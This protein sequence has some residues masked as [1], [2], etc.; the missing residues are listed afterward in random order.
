MVWYLVGVAVG[1]LVVTVVSAYIF[2]SICGGWI[3]RQLAAKSSNRLI[4][5]C[6]GASLAIISAVLLKFIDVERMR[7]GDIQ[8]PDIVLAALVVFFSVWTAW[9]QLTLADHREKA[10]ERVTEATKKANDAQAEE[11]FQY[12]VCESFLR[13]V[14]VKKDR[15]TRILERYPPA[16]RNRKKSFRRIDPAHQ[17]LVAGR[18]LREVREGLNPEVQIAALAEATREIF[19]IQAGSKVGIRVAYFC[20]EKSQLKLK[21]CH[22]GISRTPFMGPTRKDTQHRFRIKD[23]CLSLAAEA[24]KTG[25]LLIVDD[26]DAA[27]SGDSSFYYCYDE[28]RPTIKSIVAIPLG[29]TSEGKYHRHVI[30]LDSNVP[31]FFNDSLLDR[32][33]FVQKNLAPRLLYEV[34]M[35]D[36]LET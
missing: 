11:A 15:V 5:V 33:K 14:G 17:G 8:E 32:L 1:T 31:G 21:Y 23:K 30:C 20:L 2:S 9:H 4:F 3:D 13:V 6:V 7:R 18:K 19:R 26:A 10:T 22:D 29:P 24:A 35:Q 12:F 28:Q 27:H 34:V 16:H 25:R 36:L